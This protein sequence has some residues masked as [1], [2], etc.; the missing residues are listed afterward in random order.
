M[1]S[2]KPSDLPSVT[3]KGDCVILIKLVHGENIT[4]FRDNDSDLPS[5]LENNSY[6]PSHMGSVK[7][8]D[9]WVG[10]PTVCETSLY[11]FNYITWERF[12]KDEINP[13]A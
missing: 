11:F 5:I 12:F 9:I 6:L 3:R 13:R 10:N 4:N 8:P 7:V 1:L 2:S